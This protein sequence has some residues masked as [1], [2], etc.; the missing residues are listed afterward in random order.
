MRAK[1]KSL[2]SPDV[3]LDRPNFKDPKDVFCLVQAEIGSENSK[4]A[5]IFGFIVCTPLGLA[6]EMENKPI[7]SGHGLLIVNEF[8]I[9]EIESYISS[10]C[11]QTTGKNWDEIARKL[12]L[13]GQ[14]EFEDYR[15]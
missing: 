3:D 7:I 6:G 5:D 4:G 12:G 8:N 14:W 2:H 1:L 11:N 9:Q 10:L 13:I 15:G